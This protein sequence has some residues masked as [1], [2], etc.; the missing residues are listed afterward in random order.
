MLN[1]RQPGSP[2]R[3]LQI[4]AV[5]GT[6][7]T[8]RNCLEL[9]ACAA[10][11]G[12]EMYTAYSIPAATVPRNGYQ[13]GNAGDRAS[14]ALFSRVTGLQG[15]FSKSPTV[16]LV[17]Y[18]ESVMPSVIHLNNLHANYINMSALFNYA[19]D[20]NIAVVLTLH[21][22]WF[23]TGRCMHYVVDGC[24][25]WLREC[26]KCPRLSKDNPS[27]FF[28]RSTKMLADKVEW[29]SR[30]PSLAVVGV[31]KWVT[32]EAKRSKLGKFAAFHTIPNWIDLIKFS[33]Q[34]ATVCSP[35]SD[36]AGSRFI[37]LGVASRWNEAKGLNLFFQLAELIAADECVVLVGAMPPHTKLPENVI[38]IA[39]TE[40][41][42]TLASIYSQADVFVNFSKEETFGKV[43]AE[44]LACGTPIVTNNYTAN[45]ELV[46]KKCGSVSE[47]VSAFGY[48][49]EI[50]KIRKNGKAYYA[51]ACR[52]FA[53]R[54]F[55]KYVNMAKY[56][57]LYR[58]LDHETSIL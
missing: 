47:E 56:Y 51:N 35:I 45:A 33:P 31:S 57:S 24:D 21:D 10:E 27:W 38:N 36:V 40:S 11:N 28:D 14:H 48:Y 42:E 19:A 6:G 58:S 5:Y 25:K 4:N 13:I 32:D 9:D 12:I 18:M 20:R 50:M 54:K 41:L 29:Y 53:V 23:Y 49:G 17:R 7:S 15:Y 22:C 44:S 8:G 30:V 26:G 34:A 52:E 43:A 3:V 16:K 46:G 55:E 2:T 1:D 39:A 37:I